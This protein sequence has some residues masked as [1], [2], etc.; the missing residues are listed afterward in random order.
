M[1]KE[2]ENLTNKYLVDELSQRGIIT[3]MMRQEAQSKAL[4][5]INNLN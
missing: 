2:L 3:N 1:E 5:E 4:L